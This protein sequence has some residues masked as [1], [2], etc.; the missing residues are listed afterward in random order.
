[1]SSVRQIA[2]A[3]LACI[4]ILLAAPLAWTASIE[5]QNFSLLLLSLLWA[6]PLIASTLVAYL[7]PKRKV[8]MGVIATLPALACAVG[9]NSAFQMAGQRV[10]FPGFRGALALTVASLIWLLPICTLGG[11]LGFLL[12]RK[13]GVETG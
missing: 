10:D 5:N 11:V 12:S 2:R 6:S 13:K 3:W 4:G 7:S 8:L 9:L 1:M